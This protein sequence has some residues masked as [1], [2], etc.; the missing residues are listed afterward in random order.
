MQMVAIVVGGEV[1][2]MHKIKEPITSGQL[3]ISRCNDNACELL[4]VRL[5]DNVKK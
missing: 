5:R 1:L 4:Y 2:T 3:Q